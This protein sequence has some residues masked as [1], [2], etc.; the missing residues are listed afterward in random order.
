MTSDPIE[1]A[2][3]V[4]GILKVQGARLDRAYLTE[5]ARELSVEDLLGRALGQD[6]TTD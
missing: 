2:L 3:A 1:V 5:I 6:L 4:C